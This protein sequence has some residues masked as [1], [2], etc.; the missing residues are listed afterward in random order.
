DKKWSEFFNTF[1][2]QTRI[3]RKVPLKI[4]FQ[5]RTSEVVNSSPAAYTTLAQS[6][7]LPYK[8]YSPVAT[9]IGKKHSFLLIQEPEPTVITL[10]NERVTQAF[11]ANF[12]SMWNQDVRIL[13]GLDAAQQ[14][15]EEMLEVGG[16]D[17]V[18]ARGYLYNNRTEYMNSWAKRAEKRGF[19]WRNV[20]DAKTRGHPVTQFSFAQTKYTLPKEFVDLTVYWIYGG[21]V[22]INN[23][24]EKEPLLIVIEN[25]IIYEMY[26]K[27][28]EVL[29]NQET[30]VLKGLD[31]VQQIFEE[32]L[33]A[34]SCD[35][36]GARGYFIDRRPEYTADWAKRAQASGFRLRNITDEG[37]RGH[38]I[39][40][41]PFVETKY[42]L[43]K[44]FADLSVFWIYGNK[45]VITNWAQDEPVCVVIENPQM[46]DLYK[47]QFEMLWNQGTYVVTGLDA[48]QTIFEEMLDAG[49]CDFIGG[50]GW[51]LER[52]PEY[53]KVW[54]RKAIKKG[55]TMRNVV[56]EGVR[57]RIITR[58]PFADT[59]YTLP[60]EFQELSVFW[61]YGKKVVVVT[62]AQGDPVCVVIESKLMHDLY[63]AQFEVLWNKK[64]V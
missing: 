43:P 16:C 53:A 39:T 9:F 19:K 4:L 24:S 38:P 40:Q 1:H 13:R 26:K 25:P 62:Y 47:K 29:W 20:T 64:L 8:S 37:V 59:R 23:W 11:K 57:G 15:F 54:E 61:I 36:I 17:L 32:I 44:E 63:Q 55:F 30:V 28:F 12:E 49:H 21:K 10:N 6:K 41:L 34:G 2:T 56:D 51:F 31:A 60:P 45:L 58:L 46:H 14:C 33:E 18:G 35:Q 42:T 22:V 52:R 27:Q 5:E 50:K 7:F 3:P 48:V